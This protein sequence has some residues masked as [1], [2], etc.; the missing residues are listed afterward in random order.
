M[1]QKFSNTKENGTDT[2]HSNKLICISFNLFNV[3]IILFLVY[4]KGDERNGKKKKYVYLATY[5]IM[6]IN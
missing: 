6:R 4:L 3:F 1:S 5:C 2:F